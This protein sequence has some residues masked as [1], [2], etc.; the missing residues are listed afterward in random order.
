MN[1]QNMTYDVSQPLTPNVF[2]APADNV[3]RF[4]GWNTSADG[5]GQSYSDN[6]SVKN[7]T[8][9]KGEVITLYAQ[10]EKCYVTLINGTTQVTTTP[11]KTTMTG[12]VIATLPTRVIMKDDAPYITWT[13]D[14]WY[15]SKTADAVKILD[16]NGAIT[17]SAT[18]V[19][20]YTSG[21]RFTG[22]ISDVKLYARWSTTLF[23]VSNTLENGKYII[24]SSGTP[25]VVKAAKTDNS[26]VLRVTDMTVCE[27]TVF[28]E[29]GNAVNYVID[30]TNVAKWTTTWFNTN[31]APYNTDDTLKKNH[32]PDGGYMFT[33]GDKY[34]R[35]DSNNNYY[36]ATWTY[37][38]NVTNRVLWK[39]S[40]DEDHIGMLQSSFGVREG[41]NEDS[42]LT[43]K[44][45]KY[46]E[47]YANN[48]GNTVAL[49][50]EQTVYSFDSAD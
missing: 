41:K 26:N 30:T 15:T 35:H 10:W 4:K 46:T 45:D 33:I 1:N 40:R 14:G 47:W 39:Y 19:A 50:K 17:A 34:L 36:S 44:P 21:G 38:N 3:W 11:K 9:Q 37:Q 43:L 12:V 13:L 16:A 25:G 27:K 7:L 31:Q 2:T 28:D 20:G 6:Q 49:F 42:S 32:W 48:D 5:S 22:D 29:K 23:A 8:D 24:A 18:D